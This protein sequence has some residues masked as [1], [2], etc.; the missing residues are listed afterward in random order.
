MTKEFLE[1]VFKK[2]F[3]PNDDAYNPNPI[4]KYNMDYWLDRFLKIFEEEYVM[5]ESERKQFIELLDNTNSMIEEEEL[6]KFCAPF[7]EANV[8]W[9]TK[10]SPF[11]KYYDSMGLDGKD[12]K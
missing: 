12:S 10:P 9:A 6:E 4:N 3:L 5:S 1:K 7:R 2:T 8:E 11:E